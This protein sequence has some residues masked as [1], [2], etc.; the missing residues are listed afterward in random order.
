[1]NNSDKF[2]KYRKD[3]STIVKE[4]LRWLIFIF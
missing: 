1:V 4:L 2:L 3:S